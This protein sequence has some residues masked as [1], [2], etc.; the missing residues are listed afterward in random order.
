MILFQS[1]KVLVNLACTFLWLFYFFHFK[2]YADYPSKDFTTKV[3]GFYEDISYKELS[4][5]RIFNQETGIVSGLDYQF[6]YLFKEWFFTLLGEHSNGT[7]NYVGLT[8]LGREKS[9]KTTLHRR[10]YQFNISRE[11]VN[12][13]DSECRHCGVL[14][15]FSGVKYQNTER[16]IL[17][18]AKV[19]GLSETYQMDLAVIGLT[20]KYPQLLYL[21]W[22]V[23]LS[24]EQSFNSDLSINFLRFYDN[25]EIPLNKFSST[26]LELAVGYPLNN[27]TSL[28]LLITYNQSDMRQSDT[29]P[30]LSDGI[31]KGSFYQPERRLQA[32]KVGLSLEVFF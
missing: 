26:E 24:H 20:W 22:H 23:S 10:L 28:G 5:G 17:S 32:I 2:V 30:L 25:H 31:E 11:L 3:T 1:Q 18:Q 9:T 4:E 14:F 19:S 7:L 27:N 12:F 29:F 16:N 8:Q 6:S 15:I 21:D 13:N